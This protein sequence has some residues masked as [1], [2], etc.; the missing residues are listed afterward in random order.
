MLRVQQGLQH[1]VSLMLRTPSAPCR[2][3]I[4]G[5]GCVLTQ[6]G[7]VK[8]EFTRSQENRRQGREEGANVTIP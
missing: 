3:D 2:L 4:T 6:A 8:E 7:P 1:T 5:Q